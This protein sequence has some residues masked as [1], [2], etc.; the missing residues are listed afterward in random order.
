MCRVIMIGSVMCAIKKSCV[1]VPLLPGAFEPVL[2]YEVTH[3]SNH[4]D[5]LSSAYV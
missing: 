4:W 5:T 2:L 1:L 3:A